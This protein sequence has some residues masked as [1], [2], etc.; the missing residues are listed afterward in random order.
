MAEFSEITIN[1][2]AIKFRSK[3]EVYNLLCSEGA[4]YLPP[5]KDTSHSFI[6]QILVGDK[7]YLKWSSVKVCTVP[8]YKMLRITDL[9]KFARAQVGI[10]FT[11]QSTSIQ[12]SQIDNGYVM[13]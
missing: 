10:D 12:N 1:K 13:R 5:V 9:I 11:C 6:S 2:L 8:H 7:K 3:K 4:A